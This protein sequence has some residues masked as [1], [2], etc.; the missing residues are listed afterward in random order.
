MS[1][2]PTGVQIKLREGEKRLD[3][4]LI[5]VQ[6]RPFT[7]NRILMIMMPHVTLAHTENTKAIKLKEKNGKHAGP[8]IPRDIPL[9]VPFQPYELL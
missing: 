2:L 1:F 3:T 7:L 6:K 9:M 8:E 4:F 5:K